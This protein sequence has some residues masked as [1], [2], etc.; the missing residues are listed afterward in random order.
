MWK[1]GEPG[2]KVSSRSLKLDG[3]MTG[4]GLLFRT[5]ISWKLW[6]ARSRLYRQLR[7]RDWAL[8]KNDFSITDIISQL[9]IK[10]KGIIPSISANNKISMIRIDKANLKANQTCNC[11]L[12]INSDLI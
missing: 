10:G 2:S 4:A 1:R 12:L 3:G 5:P 11:D 8:E 7:K 6:K 9:S